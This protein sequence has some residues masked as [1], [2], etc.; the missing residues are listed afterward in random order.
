MEIRPYHPQDARALLSSYNALYQTPLTLVA[1]G[2]EMGALLRVNGRIWTILNPQKQPVGY[3]SIEPVTGLPGLADLN[4]LIDPHWQ[5]R[6]LGSRLL[7]HI[8]REL[9]GGP[10]RQLSHSL[11]DPDSPAA[12]FLRHHRFQLSHQEE[13]L[14]LTEWNNLPQPRPPSTRCRVARLVPPERALALFNQLYT[15]AFSPH[16]WHQPYSQAELAA[17]W[18]QTA[19]LRFLWAEDQA[20]GFVWLHYPAP[21]EAEIEPMGIVPEMQGKGY[22][23]YLLL[24]TLHYLCGRRVKRLHLG[25]WHSNQPAR[26]LYE[27][28]GFRHVY[29]RSHLTLTL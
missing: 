5:R 7:G 23:R 14:L 21:G 24:D 8:C 15:A 1:F 29:T 13:N 20:I 18:Q 17:T 28:L 11:T 9:V 22:G 4:G 27:S 16:P 3:A 26:A 25:V 6:G 10:M 2:D 19:D 12:H